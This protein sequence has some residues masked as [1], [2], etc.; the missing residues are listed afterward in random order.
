MTT[1]SISSDITLVSLIH[2]QYGKEL[3]IDNWN[4]EFKDWKLQLIS[5]GKYYEF[6]EKVEIDCKVTHEPIYRENP[7]MWKII[8]RKNPKT[9]YFVAALSNV[10]HVKDRSHNPDDPS[11]QGEN[12]KDRGHFIADSFEKY[13]LTN[14]E[15][16]A[17]NSQS[18]QFFGINNKS[19]I[20]PQD[21]RANRNSKEYAGQ[22]RF[23]QKV[24]NYL[25]KSTNA[26]EE[27]YYEIEEIKIEEKVLG[28]RIFIH[29]NQS[30]EADI[31][32][33][34]PEDRD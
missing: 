34:I 26:N 1:N 18:N 7:I 13:L 19:N 2:N 29:W 8:L 4:C 20:S 33:F 16:N 14:D 9:N 3:D 30:D 5:T 27:V 32:V 25:E 24:R 11:I 15:R 23:E 17:N 21:F 10:N 31:H 28:R 6:L 22:L 12:T